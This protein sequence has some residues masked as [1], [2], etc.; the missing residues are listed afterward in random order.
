M[1]PKGVSAYLQAWYD[2]LRTFGKGPEARA[3]L[4]YL[5]AALGPMR[6]EELI[7]IDA[8]DGLDEMEFDDALELINRYVTGDDEEG[9]SLT[10]ERFRMW[11]EDEHLPKSAERYR[12]AL[13]RYCA[14]QRGDSRYA[15][16]HY[17]RH[18]YELERYDDLYALVDH[19]WRDA[20]RTHF[21]SLR[22][23]AGNVDLVMQAAQKEPIHWPQ[24]IR[25]CL[26][27]ARAISQAGNIPD[28]L[29]SVLAQ[30]D[31]AT[32]AVGYVMLR[33]SPEQ[34]VA[35]YM[36]VA[37][38]L[39]ASNDQGGARIQ[40]EQARQVA[41]SIEDPYA[42]ASALA[43]VASALAATDAQQA[44]QVAE[45]I[46][47]PYAKARAL[48]GVASALAAT[49][50]QQ[51][52]AATGGPTSPAGGRE[53]REPVRESEC[54]G[55]RGERPGRHR[56]PTSPAGG[57]EHRETRY[58][59]ARA[60]AGVASALAATDAQ[61]ARQ[62]AESIENPYAKASALAGVASAL[63]ATDAQQAR[64]VAPTSP[65]GGREHRE[66]VRESVCAGGRGERPGRHRCPTSPA[67][68]REHRERVRESEC[69]G[70]RGERPGRHRCP[71]SPAGGREHRETVGK[72][73]RWRAWRAPWPPPMP[74]KPGRW[75]NKPGR[76]P[77]ASRTRDSEA[78]ALAGVASALAAPGLAGHAVE[79]RSLIGPNN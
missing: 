18:L 72:R 19:E 32:E 41:E 48:A 77:R 1:R 60:L 8:D 37:A 39:L 55:G 76:W 71:T 44:R 33:K 36:A 43:G 20:H 30:L 75:P 79:M 7:D 11:L 62:V 27:Y 61:Q 67:G 63:A 57:R 66:P 26:L 40:L 23:F 65:A 64:Q 45:S 69:A 21:G 38:G 53:H 59:K 47:N 15:L 25:G 73:V 5:Y 78:R 35:G 17:A 29:L 10:N 50:A 14:V 22:Y 56:C 4:G 31:R 46:E 6:P 51:A 52:L 16:L 68:G 2:D 42:K 34:Q 54:A 3:L 70:G 58:A 12:S 28:E 9:L 74:N 13:L 49:D 24:F